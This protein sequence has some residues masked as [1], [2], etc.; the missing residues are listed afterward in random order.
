[1]AKKAAKIEE[2]KTPIKVKAPEP[3]PAA[4]Q[5]TTNDLLQQVI[6]QNNQIITLLTNLVTGLTPFQGNN[7]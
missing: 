5:P 1:M 3:K 6:G 7:Q 4:S 2:V